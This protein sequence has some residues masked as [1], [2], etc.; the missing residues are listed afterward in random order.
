LHEQAK[1]Y[2]V[3]L[4]VQIG[5]TPD[6]GFFSRRAPEMGFKLLLCELHGEIGPRILRP[7]LQAHLF[8]T[9]AKGTVPS[10]N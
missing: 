10:F 6:V 8:W 4:H 5:Y 1:L 9:S 3:P 2:S 7:L